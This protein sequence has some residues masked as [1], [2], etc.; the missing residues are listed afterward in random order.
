[1]RVRLTRFDPHH[2]Y[3]SPAFLARREPR[4]YL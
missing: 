4:V 3:H 2:V 1:V